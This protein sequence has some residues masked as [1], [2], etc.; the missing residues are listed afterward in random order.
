MDNISIRQA[1]LDDLKTIQQLGFELSEYERKSW[2]KTLDSNWSFSKE[3]EAAY[4]KAI[5]EKISLIVEQDDTPIGYLICK[6][7][8][9]GPNDARHLV[10]AY[11]ENIYVKPDFRGSG[12][13]KKLFTELCTRCKKENVQKIDV[14]VNSKN[15]PAIKFY[16]KMGYSPSR[17]MM[18]CE[19][20]DGEEQRGLEQKR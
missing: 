14:M 2:D 7:L 15:I 9:P 3:G 16:E 18:S 6:I 10:T 11:L 1:T 20:K 4:I 13:G 17:L 5:S 8:H 19:L 12:I